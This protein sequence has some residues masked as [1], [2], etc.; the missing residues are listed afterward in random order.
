MVSSFLFLTL[1][2]LILAIVSFYTLDRTMQIVRIHSNINQLEIFTLNLIKS[3]NDFFNIETIHDD[4]FKTHSSLFLTRRDSINQRIQLK[5]AEVYGQ[6]KNKTYNIDQNLKIIDSTLTLYNKKFEELEKI[7]FRKGFKDYGL[8]GAMRL[9]AH[10]LEEV[11]FGI[12]ISKVLYLRRHEKDFFLRHDTAY[13]TAFIDRSQ[14]LL[15]ELQQQPKQNQQAIYHIQEYQ[16]LF[17]ELSDIQILIGLSDNDGLRTELNSLT[18]ALSEQFFL[19]SEYSLKQSSTSQDNARIFYITALCGAIFFSLIS[20]YWI[21]KRL[22]EP[23]TRLSKIV[24]NTIDSKTANR[25]DFNLNNAADE[26]VILTSSFVSLMSQT[27]VQMQEIKT[28]SKQLRVR[29]KELKKLNKELDQFLY[30]TAHDLR[31]PLTSLLGLINIMRYENKQS[32]MVQY[33]DL[34]DKSIHRMEMFIAQIASFSKN[35]IMKVIPERLNLH[36][37]VSEIFEYHNFAEGA[38]KISKEII[39]EDDMINFYS[40]HNRITILFNN[41]IS[42]AIRYADLKKE[43]SLIHVHAKIDNHEAFIE[44]RDNGIGIAQEHLDKIFDMFYRAHE[45]SKGSGLGLFIFFKTIKKLKGKVRV[46]STEGLGTT[47]FIWLPNLQNAKTPQP[48]N[49][50]ELMKS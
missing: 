44:F 23:I 3:D 31:S 49:L 25:I 17:F 8:E 50:H 34:M 26:V 9:H 6:S 28:K 18:V 47:F 43:K 11:S 16:R 10:K 42:N 5:I 15:N 2:I 12:D 21:S 41:L 35:K 22:S 4:Y 24:N 19:L 30:S 1:L 20:G 40:D 48:Q 32:E 36:K 14:N 27:K 45:N 46:E 38:D 29:N 13:L 37:M 7:L 39:V 33:F